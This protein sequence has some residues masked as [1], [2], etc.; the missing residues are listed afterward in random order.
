MA[1]VHLP[2]SDAAGNAPKTYV[3]QSNVLIDDLLRIGD[4]I[5]QRFEIVPSGSI[6]RSL[7]LFHVPI[8]FDDRAFHAAN[9]VQCVRAR[10][11]GPA[12]L[13]LASFGVY[14]QFTSREK[15]TK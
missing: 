2:C 14:D 7:P 1:R 11:L 3:S 6:L 5:R 13:T 8:C 4:M 15:Y 12:N 9:R 10:K